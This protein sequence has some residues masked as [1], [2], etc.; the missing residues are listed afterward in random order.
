LYCL[1]FF[2]GIPLVGS[3]WESRV[4]AFPL[5]TCDGLLLVVPPNFFLEGGRFSLLQPRFLVP[6]LV[7]FVCK[8]YQ[9]ASSFPA[10]FFR[11]H[12]VVRF[13]PSPPN[14]PFFMVY[15]FFSDT[16]HTLFILAQASRTAVCQCG[17]SAYLCFLR[18]GW[19]CHSVEPPYSLSFFLPSFFFFLRTFFTSLPPG[20]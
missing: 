16:A 18:A 17:S 5:S 11:S 15:V 12:L 8:N 14:S 20:V 7:F 10:F 19:S 9:M 2:S 13:S 6:D 1:V 3:V 4:S